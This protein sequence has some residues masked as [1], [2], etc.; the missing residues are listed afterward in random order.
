M[1][2]LFVTVIQEKVDSAETQFESTIEEIASIV[3]E[4]VVL[5]ICKKRGWTFI[6]GMGTYGFY[7]K[8]GCPIMEWDER[9][10]ARELKRVMSILHIEVKGFELGG[11]VA[12]VS[13]EDYQI[14]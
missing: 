2:K 4:K 5:P 13:K 1:S 14:K 12:D 7:D 11:Y 8:K 6:S 3:R 9:T 10:K